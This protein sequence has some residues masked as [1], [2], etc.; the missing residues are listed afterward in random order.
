MEIHEATRIVKLVAPFGTALLLAGCAIPVAEAETYKHLETSAVTVTTPMVDVTE[1]VD[2]VPEEVDFSQLQSGDV[3]P[4]EDV[5]E[6]LAAIG[7]NRGVFA[8]T[9]DGDYYFVDFENMPMQRREEWSRITT[10]SQFGYV[11][12]GTIRHPESDAN[13]IRTHIVLWFSPVGKYRLMPSG[14][15]RGVSRIVNGEWLEEGPYHDFFNRQLPDGNWAADGFN[16]HEEAMAALQRLGAQFPGLIDVYD[17]T[18]PGFPK[19]VLG[20]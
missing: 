20:E 18:Q 6:A 5:E 17:V 7:P 8:P 2:E 9:G 12:M 14:G 19:I 4:E 3:I 13:E 1:V 16:T 15:A 10:S 11:G